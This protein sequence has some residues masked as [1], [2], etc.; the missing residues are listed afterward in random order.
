MRLER[1][2][3]WLNLNQ[4]AAL[5]E[6]DKSVISRHLR[7]IYREGELNETAAVAFFA[8]VQKE[9]DREVVRQVEYYNL[10][11][12]ISVGYRVNWRRGT[13]FRI[14]AT[15]VLRDH[16]RRGY[17]V[18]ERRL[19]QLR[20][21]I[22]PVAAIPHR[23]A[24]AADEVTA[25]LELVRDYSYALNLLD[26]YDHGRVRPPRAVAQEAVPITPD[27]ARRLIAVLR[28]R[29]AAGP[30]FGQEKGFLRQ[31]P[32]SDPIADTVGGM[33]ALSHAFSVLPPP[34]LPS[35]SRGLAGRLDPGLPLSYPC[36]VLSATPR[37]VRRLR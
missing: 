31:L 25:L 4:M 7:N 37:Q 2:T 35:V 30:P 15:Q 33:P 34:G 6:R 10:D 11:A 5:F 29:F 3:L 12:I 21:T 26:D 24:L 8:T 32:R 9:G 18:N 36:G 28:E 13:Q 17:T 19:A 20:K 16:L 22:R 27:E 23:R 14:W 1:E